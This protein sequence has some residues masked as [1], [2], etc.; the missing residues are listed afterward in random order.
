LWNESSDL[1]KKLYY[2]K[3]YYQNNFQFYQIKFF[4]FYFI[5]LFLYQN[6]SLKVN[7]S[8]LVC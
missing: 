6:F 2:N 4:I 5:H 8:N 1:K 3:H 7:I